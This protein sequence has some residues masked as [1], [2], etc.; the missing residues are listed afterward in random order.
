MT[1][2]HIV[3]KK[4]GKVVQTFVSEPLFCYHFVNSFE[5]VDTGEVVADMCCFEDAR[6]VTEFSLKEVRQDGFRTLPGNVR[7][8]RFKLSNPSPD[9]S[10]QQIKPEILFPQ[11]FDLPRVHDRTTCN[12]YRFAYGVGESAPDKYLDRLMKLDTQER[13]VKEY[14][15]EDCVLS[16]PV[17]VPRPGSSLED[18]GVLLALSLNGVT[19]KSSM[20][21]LQAH[22]ME[23]IANIDL[24]QHYPLTVHGRFFEDIGTFHAK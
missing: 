16:E 17:F 15:D 7:R 23:K 4:D 14:R 6:A 13:T 1:H 3:S 9:A 24:P 5:D 12:S 22:N 18:D 11:S 20:V 21:V 19:E 2:F 8:F 10:P